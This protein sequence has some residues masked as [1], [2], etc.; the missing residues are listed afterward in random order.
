[1]MAIL[2]ATVAGT[3][4]GIHDPQ[5]LSIYPAPTPDIVLVESPSALERE[6]GVVRRHAMRAYDDA[7]AHVQG[8][9][10]KWIGVEHAV[11]N[12][13][14]SIIS[15][16]ESMTPNLLYVG[17]ATLTGSILGRNRLLPTRL[18][19]PPLFL[20]ASADYL[21]P[22]TTSN[23]RAYLGGLEDAY[24]PAVAEKHEIAKAHAGMTWERVK[25]ATEGAREGVREGARGAV[26][27]VQEATGLKLR[28]TLGWGGRG[29]VEQVKEVGE[30][31]VEEV[32][33]PVEK[34]VDEVEKKEDVKRL[35]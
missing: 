19:L 9:V 31:K 33:K 4:V 17:V 16:E 24:F 30:G 18:L 14:K 20:M 6:I 35:V 5:K 13:V 27:W 22:K 2:S 34:K 21:L 32:V 11:E 25:G 3:A 10:S 8:W 15:P 26:D 28:E 1:M 23:L 29:V 12:R 7:H